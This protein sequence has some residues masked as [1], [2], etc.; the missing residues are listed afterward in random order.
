[1]M[2]SDRIDDATEA[3]KKATAA[4]GKALEDGYENAREYGERTLDYA[5]QLSGGLADFVRR[6]PLVSVGAALLI[7]YLAA[8]FVRRIPA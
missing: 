3:I 5:D 1:M 8:Q 6:E 2:M 7:G 4:S